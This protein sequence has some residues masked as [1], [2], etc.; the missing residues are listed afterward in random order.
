MSFHAS[1]TDVYTKI[2]HIVC[3]TKTLSPK[4]ITN[5][6]SNF[7]NQF[8]LSTLNKKFESEIKSMA[9]HFNQSKYP[10]A[11]IKHFSNQTEKVN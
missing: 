8:P 4:C 2:N 1:S 3:Q 9:K 11:K 10:R 6:E 5:S 7:H